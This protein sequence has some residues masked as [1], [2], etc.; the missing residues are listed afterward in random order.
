MPQTVKK[1]TVLLEMAISTDAQAARRTRIEEAAYEVLRENGYKAAS[2]LAI[3]RRARASNETLY[4][5]YGGKQALFRSLVDANAREAKTLLQE[6]LRDGGDPVAALAALGPVLLL[7]VTGEKA[8]ALNRAAAADV[9]D[10]G[11]LGRGIAQGGRDIIGALV[12]GVMDAAR[13]A[14]LIACTDVAQAVETYFGLLIG[15]LQIRRA[16]GAIG[17][18]SPK[19]A[20]VRSQRALDLFLKLHAPAE[21]AKSR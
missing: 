4:K 5:W 13:R 9:S 8:V 10:T 2:V 14:K 1:F 7:L 12:G 3:A 6:A 16:I 17:P 20:Q 19:E 11:T 21:K 15:D 18:L